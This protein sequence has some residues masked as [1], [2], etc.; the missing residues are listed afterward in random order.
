MRRK[1]GGEA[2]KAE[3]SR[4]EGQA[5]RR[6]DRDRPAPAPPPPAGG[7]AR[8]PAALG[9][10]STLLAPLFPVWRLWFLGD[11]WNGFVRRVA[12]FFFEGVACS[13][14]EGKRIARIQ[15]A[16]LAP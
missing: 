6:S 5:D 15:G 7:C 14:W 10:P 9:E 4:A 8:F 1:A 3:Q 12:C 11:G 2:T 13:C 16:L